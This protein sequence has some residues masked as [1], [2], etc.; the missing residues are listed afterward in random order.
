[1]QTLSPSSGHSNFSYASYAEKLFPRGTQKQYN[2]TFSNTRTV[3]I[4]N[5]PQISPEISHFLAN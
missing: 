4:A 3:Q 5:L 1:M 2:N